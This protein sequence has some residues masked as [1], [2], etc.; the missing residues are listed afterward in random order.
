MSVS[1]VPPC[2]P[3]L[4]FKLNKE[5]SFSILKIFYLFAFPP[6][7]GKGSSICTKIGSSHLESSYSL[8][9][10]AKLL[11]FLFSGFSVL[12]QI[13]SGVWIF[14]D[15]P[16]DLKPF[17]FLTVEKFSFYNFD[18]NIK[19]KYYITL[20]NSKAQAINE[21]RLEVAGRDKPW[22]IYMEIKSL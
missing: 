20:Q 9:V 12:V 21:T 15:S 6:L 13:C 19:H 3:K 1:K 10:L 2:S 14:T 11:V 7:S 5:L 17:W 8:L 18:A 16:P 22:I 4:T